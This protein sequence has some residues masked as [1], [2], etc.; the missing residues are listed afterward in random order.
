[1]CGVPVLRSLPTPLLDMYS[2]TIEHLKCLLGYLKNVL[3]KTWLD[4][5]SKKWLRMRSL[6]PPDRKKCVCLSFIFS[7]IRCF[8]KFSITTVMG[9]NAK[10]RVFT[11]RLG[12]QIVGKNFSSWC[13]RIGVH[14]RTRL[15]CTADR[16]VKNILWIVV[17]AFAQSAA[18]LKTRQFLHAGAIRAL[19]SWKMHRE[20]RTVH[21]K[22]SFWNYDAK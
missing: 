22:F 18:P 19:L 1:M 14:T 6:N 13:R 10:E 12:E 16:M 7:S 9:E 17:L 21:V 15:F 2:R 8:C 3:R 4:R 20:I 11:T 5:Q